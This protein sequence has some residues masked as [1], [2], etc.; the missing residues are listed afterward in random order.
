V[1]DDL[2]LPSLDAL[3][4]LEAAARL[5]TFERAADELSVTASAIGKRIAA[6]EDLLGTPLLQRGAKALS[7]SAAG[8]E[9]LEQVRP[10]LALLGSV[11]LHRRST[12]RRQRLRLSAPPTLARQVLVPALPDFSAS[13]PDIELEVVLSVPY[14]DGPPVHPDLTLRYAPLGEGELL[15]ADVLLPLASPALL[16]RHGELRH[17]EDLQRLPLLCT[18]VEPWMPWLHAQGLDWPEPSRGHR[19]VDLGLNLEAAA[20]GQGVVLA[21]P[22]L[23]RAWLR[24]GALR[25]VFAPQR[26]PPVTPPTGYVLQ[27]AEPGPAASAGAAWL[28]E[29][30]RRAAAEGLSLVMG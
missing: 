28:R 15:M 17:L 14:L 5:G 26:V 27:V 16:A 25:P 30:G 7:L 12:Q 29:A 10:A 22:S 21:R 6:L 19:L 2:R 20:H 3:R 8:K 4:A 24:S 9:Y 23:A 13:H 1:V 18:P 11:P